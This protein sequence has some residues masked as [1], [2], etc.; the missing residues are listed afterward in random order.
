MLDDAGRCRII[1]DRPASD[2]CVVMPLFR[3][4]LTT[5]RHLIRTQKTEQRNPASVRHLAIINIHYVGGGR[6]AVVAVVVT[7][8]NQIN[9][10]SF[11]PGQNT[12]MRPENQQHGRRHPI[13]R[14]PVKCSRIYDFERLRRS[15]RPRFV[16]CWPVSPPTSGGRSE[17]HLGSCGLRRQGL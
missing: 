4:R 6:V 15:A 7:T 8:D 12:A 13:A 17:S 5:I 14:R 1:T 9:K 3:E 10:W 11:S 16:E 2:V